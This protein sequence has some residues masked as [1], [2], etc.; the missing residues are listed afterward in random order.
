MH[1]I[2]IKYSAGKGGKPNGLFKILS[3][4]RKVIRLK[5]HMSTIQNNTSYQKEQRYHKEIKTHIC[6]K[7]GK[8]PIQQT[9]KTPG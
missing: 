2:D 5:V 9:T 7:K 8:L 4:M 1:N 6:T 3:F